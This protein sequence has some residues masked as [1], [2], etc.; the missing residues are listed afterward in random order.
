[1][2][3]GNFNIGSRAFIIA[4]LSANH[5]HDK[6]IAIETVRA[7]KKAGADAIK[8][9]TYRPD[10]IT[11]D[12]DNE[13]FQIN[14]GTQWDG[15]TLYDLYEEAH[16]PWEWHA[17]LFEVAKNEGL[18]C[19]SSPF[20]K[21]A[22][23]FLEELNTPA[24][25]IASFE[26]QDIPLIEYAASKG[27]PI[28]MSTGIATEE[29]IQLA[30]D[31]CR[32]AGNEEIILLKCTSSY[33]APIDLANL[34]T[35]VDMKERFGV[36]VGLSD[37]TLG[38]TVPIVA[39]S[40]G[41]RVIEKHFILNKSI[42]GP[43]ADFSLDLEEFSSM[44]KAVREAE[45]AL[46]EVT[47][48]LSEKVQKNKKFARSLFAVKDI[49]KGERFSEDNVRSIRPGYGLHPVNFNKIIGKIALKNIE[50]GSP[51]HEQEIKDFE[52]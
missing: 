9:Q 6:S 8:L 29:D 33:P 25:K 5:G 23:D 17:E 14:D 24:Y 47:Y 3:I 43:D 50:K 38:N 30:V 32:N 15:R 18:V 37:H 36:E 41:A 42:G 48:E 44:V 34:R 16:L 4:E 46:G 28:I 39:T 40:L 31:T 21:T 49:K 45:K 27:K 20:D 1:M 19:F 13:Y 10:T 12:C 51:L 7:A 26:I 2:E 35:M 11:I 22:V 52:I